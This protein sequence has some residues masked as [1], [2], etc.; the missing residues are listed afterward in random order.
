MYFLESNKV[1]YFDNIVRLVV[2][3]RTESWRQSATV[4]DRWV[5]FY[6]WDCS[7]FQ[8][9]VADSIH[10][11][12]RQFRRVGVGEV[13]VNKNQIPLRYLASELASW[14]ATC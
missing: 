3:V 6:C 4:G 2:G 9:T 13:D 8:Q 10:N 11:E 5:L 12:T 1:V 14:S 7:I